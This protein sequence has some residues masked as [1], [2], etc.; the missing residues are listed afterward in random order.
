[1]TAQEERRRSE[2]KKKK[3]EKRCK[4]VAKTEIRKREEKETHKE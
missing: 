3:N 4:R 1:M 2:E